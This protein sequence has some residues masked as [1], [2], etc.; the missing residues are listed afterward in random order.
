MHPLDQDRA[1]PE[2][3]PAEREE[4]HVPSAL[5]SEQADARVSKQA[6]PLE[7][8]ERDHGVVLG[9][10]Q[11]RGYADAVQELPAGLSGVVVIGIA[12]AES[13]RGDAVV[14]IAN[15]P[16]GV[17]AANARIQPAD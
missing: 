2:A 4:T 11:Q 1:E 7:D 14:E 3:R 13:W 17:E 10:N 12:E 5:H 9:L 15:G 6:G 16:H 8:L